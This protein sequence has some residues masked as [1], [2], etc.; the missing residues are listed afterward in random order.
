MKTEIEDLKR[1]TLYDLAKMTSETQTE[2]TVTI[3]PD[4]QEI[5]VEPWKPFEYKCPNALSAA[6]ELPGMP[7]PGKEPVFGA[8]GSDLWKRVFLS[9][10]VNEKSFSDMLRE[11]VK[12]GFD[13][14]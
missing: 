14:M 3:E 4:R 8:L 2:I 13:N 7:E 9:S 6:T 12:I 11:I 10:A 5:Q 1:I